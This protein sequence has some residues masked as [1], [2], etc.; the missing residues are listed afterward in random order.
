LDVITLGKEVDSL[1]LPLSFRL[2]NHVDKVLL[3]RS[4]HLK[5]N[6]L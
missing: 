6:F 1:A 4:I 3:Q 2:T 5:E